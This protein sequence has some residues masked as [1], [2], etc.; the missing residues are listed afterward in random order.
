MK[1]FA[2][3]HRI[4]KEIVLDQDS[5]LTSKL[6]KGVFKRFGTKLNLDIV[7]HPQTDG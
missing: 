2:R 4:P 7:Y 6:W 5:K 1:D 3:L